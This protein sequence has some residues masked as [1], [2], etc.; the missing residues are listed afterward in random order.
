M[1]DGAALVAAVPARA[2]GAAVFGPVRQGDFLKRLGIE[3]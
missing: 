1:L 3:A 2:A